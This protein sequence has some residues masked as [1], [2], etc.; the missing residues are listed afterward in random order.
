M[1]SHVFVAQS[2]YCTNPRSEVKQS[3]YRPGQAHKVPGG[4][5]SQIYRQSAH[6]GGKVVRPTH[7]PFLPPGISTSIEALENNLKKQGI[8]DDLIGIRT[9]YI[10]NTGL[11]NGTA[12]PIRLN[13]MF[14]LLE[15]WTNI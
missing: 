13:F 1:I 11:E 3:Q 4:R 2:M 14:L 7:R 5:G 6:E 9:S 12:T 8:A 15:E 10:P